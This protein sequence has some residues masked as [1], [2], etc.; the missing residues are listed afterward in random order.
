RLSAGEGALER[1][2]Q[3]RAGSHY[4][5]AR[6]G[7]RRAALQPS[8]PLAKIARMRVA[9]RRYRGIEHDMLAAVGKRI[10]PGKRQ[11]LLDRI[12]HPYQRQRAAAAQELCRA[13]ERC[14]AVGEIRHDDKAR[15]G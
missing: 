9:H 2:E 6:T 13:L 8:A 4:M 3:L 14:L 7:Q 12:E 5:A 11:A 10:A 1:R 15:A